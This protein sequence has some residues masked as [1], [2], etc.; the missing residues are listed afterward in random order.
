MEHL[1]QCRSSLF[2]VSTPFSAGIGFTI[3]GYNWIITSETLVRDNAYVVVES[4]SGERHQ[5]DIIYVDPL[6]NVAF[7][8]LPFDQAGEG[9]ELS[10]QLQF[11]ADMLV[12]APC[13]SHQDYALKSGQL[14]EAVFPQ[15]NWDYMVHNIQIDVEHAGGPLV[16]H[17]AQ[18]LAI[19][20]F[21]LSS[22]SNL[23]TALPVLG[24]I[25]ALEKVKES[26]PQ[27]WVRCFNCRTF[28]SEKVAL[29]SQSCTVCNEFVEFPKSIPLY[30]PVGVGRT[31]EALI[32]EA[33]FDPVLCRKGTH[34]WMIQ[35]GSATITLDYHEKSGMV[36]GEAVLCR[37]PE[38]K[39]FAIYEYLLKENQHL[40]HL[41]FSVHDAAVVLSLVIN[42]ITL[43]A[44]AG[45]EKLKELFHKADYF[46]DY[47]IESFGATRY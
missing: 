7:I 34:A 46:D 26:A 32:E 39:R 16:N 31:I 14:T 5:A 40:Q 3:K 20:N 2:K 9:L 11:E 19:N 18:L 24:F 15:E 36:N 4:L 44:D 33:G 13:I 22:D 42:D 37:L 41:S 30:E 21:G 45:L 29:E 25:D 27:Q 23:F 38:G 8:D 17:Q 6:L 10:E 47:L 1:A 43:H 28:L 35:V 12:Y